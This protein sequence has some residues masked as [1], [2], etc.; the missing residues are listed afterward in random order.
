MKALNLLY[1]YLFSK[2][3]FLDQKCS[4]KY[5]ELQIVDFLA[6][7]HQKH[8]LNMLR[9]HFSYPS[10]YIFQS[11]SAAQPSKWKQIMFQSHIKNVFIN[12]LFIASVNDRLQ[13]YSS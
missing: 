4:L 7:I 11:K 2:K 9:S 3:N 6:I 10:S 12:K 1:R 8:F 13:N 5:N